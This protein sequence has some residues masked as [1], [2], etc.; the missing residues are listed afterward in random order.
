MNVILTFLILMAPFAVAAIVS[1]ASH[2][3]DPN[4]AWLAAAANDPDWYRIQHDADAART[5][6]EQV[7]AWPVSGVLGERR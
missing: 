5:R 6:F 3:S 2:R 4:R 1:W 7:P